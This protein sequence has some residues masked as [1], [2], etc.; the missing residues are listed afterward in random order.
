VQTSY[1]YEQPRAPIGRR[2]WTRT[3]ARLLLRLNARRAT[4]FIVQTDLMKEMLERTLPG[5]RGKVTVIPHPAPS[6][7]IDSG[8]RRTGRRFPDADRLD[9]L[10]PADGYPHKNHALLGRIRA[11]ESAA[12]PVSRLTLTIDADAHPNPGIAWIECSGFLAPA[13]LLGRY[14]EADA[15]VYLSTTES[16]GLPLIEAMHIGLPVVAPDLPYA[17]TLC[18]DEAIYFDVSDVESLRLA[19]VELRR[20]LAAGW[21][22]DWQRRR[23]CQAGDWAAVADA[24]V[25]VARTARDAPRDRLPESA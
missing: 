4:A 23:G 9:L 6:W 15:L 12:W 16:Y 1:L 13:D 25:A 18:G 20:R 5:V 7:L 14:G 2:Q 19:L 24:F 11:D 8:L 22:P 21:W 17:R 3:L 10:Y